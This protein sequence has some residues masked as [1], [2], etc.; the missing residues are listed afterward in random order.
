ML[1][2]DFTDK[3]EDFNLINNICEMICQTDEVTGSL[4]QRSG[5]KK[6]PPAVN[7]LG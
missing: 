2:T 7:T 3:S 1:R 4:F 6:W 5:L